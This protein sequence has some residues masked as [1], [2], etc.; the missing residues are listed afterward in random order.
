M[1]FGVSLFVS[2]F[3]LWHIGGRGEP[4]DKL[5]PNPEVANNGAYMGTCEF[6]TPD[7]F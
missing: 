3:G 2:S 7:K 5:N 1:K 6:H 4:P